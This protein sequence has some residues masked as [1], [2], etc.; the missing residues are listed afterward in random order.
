[1]E[2]AFI[3]IVKRQD[4]MPIDK[5]LERIEAVSKDEIA[6]PG[7]S[8]AP[9]NDA[10]CPAQA[11]AGME[12]EWPRAIRMLS[13]KKASLASYLAEGEPERL[14][15]G[16]LKVNFPKVPALHRETLEAPEN[17]KL[18]EGICSEV[19]G[20]PAKI[21]FR[22]TENFQRKTNFKFDHYE[23]AKKEPD[24]VLKDAMEVLNGSVVK[25]GGDRLNG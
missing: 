14:E 5:L 2:F 13:A 10:G 8:E 23:E 11:G 7:H 17:R 24:P 20:A 3:K 16:V 19:F 4:F 1:M 25:N 21:E 6:S 12:T 15:N 9:R 18:I 22:F